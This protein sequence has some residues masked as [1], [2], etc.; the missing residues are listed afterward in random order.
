M[1]IS[2]Q[3]SPDKMFFNAFLHSLVTMRVAYVNQR[4]RISFVSSLVYDPRSMVPDP[5]IRQPG[6]DLPRHTW[7]MLNRFRTGRGTCRADLHQW[8]RSTSESC[9][10]GQ[11]QTMIH[12]VDSC[13]LSRFEGGL[14]RLNTADDRAVHWLETAAKKALAK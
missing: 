9:S 6:F 11:K 13:P 7:S 10:C 8:G 4:I 12:I 14:Q 1:G 3:I 5:T 2:S